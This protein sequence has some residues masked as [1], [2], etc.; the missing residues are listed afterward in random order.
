MD[1]AAEKLCTMVS[2]IPSGCCQDPTE[3][4][5]ETNSINGSWVEAAA[6]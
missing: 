6:R 4:T 3:E 5:L 1:A 2:E